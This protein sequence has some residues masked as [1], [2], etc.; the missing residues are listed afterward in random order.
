MT[1]QDIA[2]HPITLNGR[3]RTRPGFW[4][5]VKEDLKRNF[6]WTRPGFRAVFAYRVAAWAEKLRNPVARKLWRRFAKSM[7]RF[8]RNRYGIELYGTARIG[9]RL[10]IGHQSGIVIH[11]YAIIGDDVL[12]RQGVTMGIAREYGKAA[13][14]E[15]APTIGDRVDIGAGAII[16]GNVKIGN[17]VKIFPNAVVMTDVPANSTVICAMSKVAQ[18]AA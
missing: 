10:L 12:I 1:T 11:E 4:T 7:L 3:A 9:R 14:P 8:V 13:S 15:N 2:P 18:R 17:D 5:I 6:D 16:M